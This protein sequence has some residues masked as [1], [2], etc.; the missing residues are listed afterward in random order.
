M[1]S[2]ETLKFTINYF[3]KHINW[4]NVQEANGT[5]YFNMCLLF[6]RFARSTILNFEH[7][8][9]FK[10]MM[11]GWLSSFFFN[12]LKNGLKASETDFERTLFFIVFM[13]IITRVIHG[14]F[15]FL[16]S[17]ICLN[18]T[19]FFHQDSEQFLK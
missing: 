10:R 2:V 11:K 15:P 3:K 1:I 13:S 4:Y 8:K 18:E 17:N 7:T 12:L 9:F 6:F 14:F 5:Y 16:A 19:D